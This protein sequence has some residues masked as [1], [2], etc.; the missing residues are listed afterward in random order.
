MRP[1]AFARHRRPSLRIALYSHDTMG[2]GHVRRNLLIAGALTRAPLHAE[3]L[4]ITGIREAGA[5]TMAPGIDCLTLPA[6]AKSP[7]GSYGPRSLRMATDSLVALRSRTIDAALT[8]FQPHLLIVDNVPRGA[9]SELDRTLDRLARERRTRCVL[10]L[11]DI[12]DDAAVVRAQWQAADHLRVVTE[13]YDAV[14]VYGSPLICD[15]AREYGFPQRLTEK[16]HYLGYLDHRRRLEATGPDLVP[17]VAAETVCCVGGGQDGMALAR[18]FAAAELPSVERAALICGPFMPPAHRTALAQV[19]GQRSDMRLLDFLEEPLPLMA[20]ARRIVAMGGYNTTVEILT[21]GKPGLIV[22]RIRPR[23]EQLVRAER[24]Q[25]LHL[26]DLLHPDALDAAAIS[27]WLASEPQP[28][29]AARKILDF[30]ALDRLPHAAAQLV[31]G[32]DGKPVAPQAA[33]TAYEMYE[34]GVLRCA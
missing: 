2:L 33:A 34:M 4:L 5:F 32:L 15:A 26:V 31:E 20:S 12:L 1:G 19:V 13:A 29:S 14:W 8:Q 21:L 17:A 9:M 6:Y 27:A 7:N 3:V 28:R 10:G 24:L 30:Q 11:R 23:R 22:P 18:A 25:A 16:V